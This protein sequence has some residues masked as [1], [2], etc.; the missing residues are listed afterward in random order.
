MAWRVFAASA[1][2]KSH[3]DAGTPCQD[4]FARQVV[5]D[6]LLAVVC[7]GAGS[8][9]LSH[10]G[11]EAVSRLVVA[12]LAGRVAAGEDLLGQ[13]PEAFLA[14]IGD[15]VAAARALLLTEATAAGVEL[16]SY[17]CTLVGA[18]AAGDRGYFFHVGDGQCVAQPQAPD[19]A[20]IMSLP[21]NGEYANETYFVT[22]EEWRTHLR[23]TQI[24]LP[25]RAV[26][27]MSDGAAPFVLSKGYASLYRPFMDPVEHFLASATEADGCAA[28]AGTL[29]DPR[30]YGITGDDKTLLIALW[31]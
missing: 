24:T 7:D 17:A 4:A 15:I 10:V 6:T 23:V 12:D 3:I 30:T 21:E 8:Q 14:S 29:E 5:D 18:I 22:G 1:I 20:E 26:A 11:A 13:S 28:L 19:Q 9:P 16:G 25:V 31:Q 2:G 27:L